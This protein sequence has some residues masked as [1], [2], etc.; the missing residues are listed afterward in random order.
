VATIGGTFL[1]DRCLTIVAVKP[2]IRKVAFVAKVFEH[3]PNPSTFH[4]GIH[5]SLNQRRRNPVPRKKL[6]SAGSWS[7]VTDDA[8]PDDLRASIAPAARMEEQPCPN[9]GQPM[10]A[11]WGATCGNCRPRMASPK[12]IFMSAVDGRGMMASPGLSLGWF[13]V[14]SSLDTAQTGRLIELTTPVTILSRG[15][16]EST[17]LETWV[18]FNDKFISNGHALIHRPKLSTQDE[19]FSIRDREV[20]GP[21]ANGTFVNSHKLTPGEAV[22][23]SE[24]DIVRVGRTEL[25]FKSLWLS[26]SGRTG[27]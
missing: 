11:A 6:S 3:R 27:A 20:P 23:L 8:A 19:A 12:T 25:M 4:H 1:C 9:C 17:S 5:R 22:E 21:S 7:K 2:I 13:V 26:P 15:A 16:Q 10:L 18:D 24:G 14:L